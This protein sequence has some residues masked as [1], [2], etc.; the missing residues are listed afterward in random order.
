[1]TIIFLEIC[2]FLRSYAI[3]LDQQ[4]KEK[5]A[6]QIHNARQSSNRAKKDKIKKVLALINEIEIQDSCSSDEY[7]VAVPPTETAMICKSAQIPPDIWMTLPLEAKKWLL[8]ER[9]RQQQADNKMKKSLALNKSTAVPN[10][11]DTNN[12][13]MP[14][15][16]ARVKN[17]AKGQGGYNQG[18]YRSNFYFY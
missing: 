16:Y 17:V 15:Q 18:E 9:K 11:K 3:R 7:L 1:V 6:R 12:S 2:N 4:Y 5:A 13:K 10:N 8:N 14:N